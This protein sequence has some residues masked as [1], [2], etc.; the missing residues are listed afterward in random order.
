M[1]K[2]IISYIKDQQL[3]PSGAEQ[4]TEAE[5]FLELIKRE[6]GLVVER[7]TDEHGKPLY[8]FIHRTFQEY[9]AA[10]HIYDLYQEEGAEAISEFL[11]KHLYDPHWHEVILLL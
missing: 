6:A 11:R 10:T 2:E 4:N 3:L 7:G 1:R 9:F 5:L 8:G